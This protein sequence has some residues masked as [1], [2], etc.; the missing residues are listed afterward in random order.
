MMRPRYTINATPLERAVSILIERGAVVE[1]T[2]DRIIRIDGVALTPAQSI[3]L[4]YSIPLPT[5]K[6]TR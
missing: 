3:L 6:G 4:V 1:H 5:T 2:D